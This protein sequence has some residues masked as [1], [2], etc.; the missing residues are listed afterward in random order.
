MESFGLP[1]IHI[2]A[3]LVHLDVDELPKSLVLDRWAKRAK[4]CIESQIIQDPIKGD[5]VLYRM[6]VGSF[7]HHYKR[8]AKVTCVVDEDYYDMWDKVANETLQLELKHG[9]AVGPGEEAGICS[10][11]VKDPVVA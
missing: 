1:C 8:L 9:L 7:V 10:I 5:S 6:H 3:V 2:I 4:Q 11:G